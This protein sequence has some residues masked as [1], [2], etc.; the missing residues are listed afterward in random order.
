M[1]N[2]DAWLPAVLTER[3]RQE[4]RRHGRPGDSAHPDTA[5]RQY[6]AIL[7]EELGEVAGAL[8]DPQPDLLREALVRV[9][10]VAAA[11]LEA[12][13]Q[14]ATPTEEDR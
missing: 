6:L 14:R 1:L 5:D 13:H 2:P 10:A 9:A 7:V 11:W 3:A 8:L 4:H 12:L